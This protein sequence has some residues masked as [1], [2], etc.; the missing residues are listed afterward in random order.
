MSH[1]FPNR[2]PSRVSGR[3]AAITEIKQA[4]GPAGA[5][6]R[7]Q[8]GSQ[9]LIIAS[10]K[11]I[12]LVNLIETVSCSHVPVL[13]TGETG[14]GKEMMARAVHELSE[15]S[16]REYLA[17]NCAAVSR[18]MIESQL[19]GH[20][21]GSFTGALNDFKGIIRAVDG[22]TLLLDEIG[23][24]DLSL[25]P[26][27]LRFLQEG[28]VHP[29]GSARPLRADVRIIAATN[30]D[31]EEDVKAGRFRADLFERLHVIRL[32]IPPLRQRREEIP[33]LVQHF[34]ERF[35][36]ET[37][38]RELFLS[39]QVNQLLF[40]YHWPRNVREL[41]NEIYRLVIMAKNG[42]V[43]GAERLSPTIR[44][45]ETPEALPG[46]A[47]L[48]PENQIIIDDSLSY[49]AAREHLEREMITRALGRA[50]GNITQT[51]AALGMDRSGLTKAIRRLG[52]KHLMTN[53]K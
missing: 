21:R 42:E 26:K 8:S 36:T 1:P 49:A 37:G 48:N 34:F 14:T 25:Q 17:F 51:A 2:Y 50:N 53:G 18:E 19:F 6:S 40:D 23:E 9:P 20:Q 35:K 45:R 47:H 39:D 43:V 4:Q 16:H 52:L 27:L 38:K 10:P 3:G 41:A 28:E 31:L 12:E 22:G 32:H 24:L 15:R 7:N 29:L 30:R 46:I 11:M 33:L 5:H 44:R 13:I